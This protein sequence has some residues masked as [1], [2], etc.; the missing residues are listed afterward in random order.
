MKIRAITAGVA[1]LLA[2]N[3]IT[4]AMLGSPLQAVAAAVCTA[5]IA[6][7]VVVFLSARP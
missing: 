7:V 1:A 4:I 6:A 2:A 3:D 5:A